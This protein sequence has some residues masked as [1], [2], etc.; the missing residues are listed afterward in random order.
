M[1]GAEGKLL[2]DGGYIKVDRFAGAERKVLPWA[3]STGGSCFCTEG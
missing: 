3:C 1:L 2:D